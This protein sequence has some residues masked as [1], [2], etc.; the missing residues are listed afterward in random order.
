MRG[1]RQLAVVLLLILTAAGAR[2]GEVIDRIVATVGKHAIL[3]SE[4]DEALR[5]EIFADSRP[6][7]SV[8]SEDVK[9]TLNRLVDQRL[10][11]DDMGAA[12]PF[13]P[14]PDEIKKRIAE[15]RA[16]IAA[17]ATDEKWRSLLTTYGLTEALVADRV[18]TQLETIRMVNQRLRPTVR[19]DQTEIEAAYRNEFLPKLRQTGAKELP[20]AEVSTRIRLI[21]VERHVDELMDS[22]LESLRGQTAIRIQL[23]EGQSSAPENP[24]PAGR[25]VSSGDA[26]HE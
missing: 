17:G 11:R 24:P 15:I 7:A 23:D 19:V 18:R 22:W 20:L 1:M 5:F 10:I 6:L 2:A 12:E 4:V 21:L 3:E 8:T 25:E 26:P 13:A 16:Q 14:T 9:S